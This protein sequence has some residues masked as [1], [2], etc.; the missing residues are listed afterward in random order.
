MT[1]KQ[2]K[3]KTYEQAEAMYISGSISAELWN[4]YCYCWQNSTPRYSGLC[5]S[6]SA[7][8]KS[9]EYSYPTSPA[10]KGFGLGKTGCWTVCVNGGDIAPFPTERQAIDAAYKID[11]PWSYSWLYVAKLRKSA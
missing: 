6:Y 3:T 7:D 2:L 4:L 9:V 8:E 11:L 10:A 1:L 5:E